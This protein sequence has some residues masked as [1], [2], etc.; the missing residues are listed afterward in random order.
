MSDR[1]TRPYWSATPS[2]R[3]VDM[4]GESNIMLPLHVHCL[5]NVVTM[6]DP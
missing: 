3:T 2:E 1:Y 6:S 5:F 4:L